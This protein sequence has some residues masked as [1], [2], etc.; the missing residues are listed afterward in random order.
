MGG[1]I[2]SSLSVYVCV[3]VH[4]ETVGKAT[5]WCQ[6]KTTRDLLRKVQGSKS[7]NASE[8]LTEETYTGGWMK[9]A[10]RLLHTSDLM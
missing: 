3:W 10:G 9:T 4:R 5:P 7:D 2:S 1:S 6:M 8:S